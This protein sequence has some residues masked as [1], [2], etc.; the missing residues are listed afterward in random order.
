VLTTGKK[1]PV[2]IL[3]EHKEPHNLGRWASKRRISLGVLDVSENPERAYNAMLVEARK[4]MAEEGA[5][6]FTYGCMSM[7]FIDIDKQLEAELGVPFMKSAKASV[8]LA[9]LFIDLELTHS[10]LTYPT[11]ERLANKN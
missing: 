6:A 7:A 4:T 5:D 8:K 3:L 1:G 10:K 2:N 9:E 11:P